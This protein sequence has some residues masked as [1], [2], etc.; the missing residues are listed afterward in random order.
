MAIYI[1]DF[2]I[3]DAGQVLIVRADGTCRRYASGDVAFF[4]SSDKAVRVREVE[5]GKNDTNNTF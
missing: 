1:P 3:P 2:R 5:E 4:N